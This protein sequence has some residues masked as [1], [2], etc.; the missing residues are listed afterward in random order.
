MV[1]FYISYITDIFM[2]EIEANIIIIKGREFCLPMLLYPQ[3]SLHVKGASGKK[4]F[5]VY[6]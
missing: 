1:M 4:M 3:K 6:D 2:N 5:Y